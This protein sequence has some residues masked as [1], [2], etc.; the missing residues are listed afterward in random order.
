MACVHGE[1]LS[2]VHLFA[3]LWT[4]ANQAPLSMGF[5]RQEYWSGLPCPLPGNLPSPG[6]KPTS[7]ISPA[8]AGGFF[9]TSATWEAPRRYPLYDKSLGY[10]IVLCTFHSVHYLSQ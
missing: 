4:V 10:F 1:L 6:I 2:H 8:L 5:S 3:T 7:L 9:T